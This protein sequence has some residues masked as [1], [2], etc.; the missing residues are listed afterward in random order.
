MSNLVK[1]KTEKCP[2]L[3]NTRLNLT[4]DITVVPSRFYVLFVKTSCPIKIYA[5]FR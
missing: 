2:Y 3:L 4:K 1:K 5:Q